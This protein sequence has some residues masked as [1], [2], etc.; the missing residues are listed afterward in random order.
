[1]TGSTTVVGISGP[2]GAG[3]STLAA[4]VAARLNDEGVRA[5]VV[6]VYGCVACRRWHGGTG[7][8]GPAESLGAGRTVDAL[9]AAARRAHAAVDAWEM[10]VRVGAARVRLGARARDSA[11]LV[12]DRSPLD[13]VVKH[14]PAPRSAAWRAYLRTIDE[15]ARIIV[16]DADAGV[17][18]VRDGEHDR[19]E[20]ER[21]RDRFRA[22]SAELG[23]DVA[24]LD[25]SGRPDQITRSCL[26]SI[27]D[28]V[29][30]P[31]A[32]RPA[33]IR[34]TAN[35]THVTPRTRGAR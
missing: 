12:T 30:R 20:L 16:L 22:V 23:A 28:L 32:A 18:S 6:H 7:G 29:R 26:D 5:A 15:Y 24:R 19:A 14:A 34:N 9:R 13:G 10:R 21:L 8:I 25:A 2:D 3:K 11:V 17:L 1:M 27:S 4:A 35:I 31:G 33:S